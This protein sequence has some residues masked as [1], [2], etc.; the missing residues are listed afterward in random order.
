[1][2]EEIIELIKK[3]KIK[4][5]DHVEIV[6]DIDLRHNTLIGEIRD[7]FEDETVFYFGTIDELRTHL[8]E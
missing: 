7:Y 5:G 1:M 6:F 3:A 2:D 8:N 4:H